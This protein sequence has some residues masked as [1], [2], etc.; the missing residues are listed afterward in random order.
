MSRFLGLLMLDTA[1]P[2]L[3]GDAGHLASWA[4]PVQA[5]VVGGASP[6]RVVRQGDAALLPAFIDAA[7]Q[8]VG[9]GAAAI[10]TSCGFLV[11]HQAALQAALPVP[12]WTSALLALPTLVAPGVITVDAQALGALHLLAAGAD[13]A[14][15]VQGLADGGHLQTTLLHNLPLLDG[16]LAQAEVVAA[17]QQLLRRCPHLQSLVLECTN[18]PPFAAAVAAATGLPVQHLVSLVHTRWRAL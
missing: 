18:L 9:Q 11:Q 1:F 10:T 15:P 14:T 16:G 8:L 3:P 17:A 7:R 13:A 4:M 6:Q 5:L 12:V 2:R